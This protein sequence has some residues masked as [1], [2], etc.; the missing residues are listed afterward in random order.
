[1]RKQLTE[2]QVRK[3]I[4]KYFPLNPQEMEWLLKWFNRKD[5]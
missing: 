1:M 2:Y 5:K 3:K 4:A